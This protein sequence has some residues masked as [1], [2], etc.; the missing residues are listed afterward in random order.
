MKTQGAETVDECFKLLAESTSAIS[1][2]WPSM[3][4]Q[5]LHSSVWFLVSRLKETIHGICKRRE[6][7]KRD[8]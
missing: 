1:I 5:F 8:Q 3:V 2:C 4:N 7:H 6:E